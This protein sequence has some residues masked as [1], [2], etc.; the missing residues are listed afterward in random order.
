MKKNLQQIISIFTVALFVF[1]AFGSEVDETTKTETIESTQSLKEVNLTQAQTDSIELVKSKNR[2]KGEKELKN[3][4]KNEDEFEGSAFYRDP[5][6]PYYSNVNFKKEI[7]ETPVE[8]IKPT[9]SK[10]NKL[11][12]VDNSPNSSPSIFPE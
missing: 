3:F 1:I 7:E 2:A 9:K 11:V 4:K 8:I 12:Q 6:T 5:R 10:K